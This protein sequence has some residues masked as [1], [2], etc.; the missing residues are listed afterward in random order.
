MAMKHKMS[1]RNMKVTP[2]GS[3]DDILEEVDPINTLGYFCETLKFFVSQR[4][5]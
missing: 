1:Q 4:S 5:S 2:Q 3:Y